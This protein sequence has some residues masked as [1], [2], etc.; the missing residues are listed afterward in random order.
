MTSHLNRRRFLQTTAASSAVLATGVW[1]EVSAQ[2]SDSPN[3][4]LNI[5]IIG[6]NG[7]GRANI[8]GVRNENIVSLCDI[9]DLSLGT[10][11]ERFP[12]ATH[13]S[14]WR[15]MIENE[16]TLDAYVISTTSH[17]HAPAAVKAMR[18]GKHVY[19]EKPLAHTV[20][21]ARIMREVFRETG[22]ATQMGTQIHAGN[23]FR[24]VVEMV[25]AGAIGPV[26]EAHVWCNRTSRPGDRPAGT[27]PIPDHL[28][29][30]LWLGPAP[31][32]PY[33][34]SYLPGNLTWNRWWD[35]GNGTLGDMG[36][37]LIDLPW[38]A[39]E[40]EAPVSAEAE[41]PAVHP[42]TYPAWLIVTWQHPAN[43]WHGEI[44]LKWYHGGRRPDSPD[45]INLGQWGNGIM[46]VGDEGQLVADY[47][48]WKL[49]PADKFADYEP[50]EQTIAASPGHYN[51][52]IRGCKEGTPTLCN[53]DYS[54]ALIENNLLGNV[55]FR[56]GQRLDWNSE[57]LAVTN[58]DEAEP[59]IRKEYREGWRI[60]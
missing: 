36:S 49:L 29:W 34:G 14:D 18:M 58:C 2:D 7:R 5:G 25:Q 31:E 8:N 48:K 11:R 42:E 39:L 27:Q 51:E 15:R 50:P 13:Y 1:S 16:K 54:G 44:T 40:L 28:H 12:A 57:E 59:L 56:M 43:D 22:V 6:V 19:C 26:R 30:D 32:R 17:T 4:K 37:H 38:W 55:A 24:R 46:F 53:F 60:L 10:A 35:F 52:W 33:H 41:G 3:E 21:E 47:G 9:N 45:G 23:T 20:Q